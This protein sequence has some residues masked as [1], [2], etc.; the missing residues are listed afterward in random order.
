MNSYPS[1]KEPS[2]L[3]SSSPTKPVREQNVQPTICR[4][5]ILVIRSY[6]WRN[7]NP[8]SPTN[9]PSRSPPPRTINIR[10]GHHSEVA[11]WRPQARTRA[12][13]ASQTLTARHQNLLRDAIFDDEFKSKLR[14]ANRSLDPSIFQTLDR[15]YEW[16]RPQTLLH[17]AKS[18]SNWSTRWNRNFKTGFVIFSRVE[19]ELWFFKVSSFIF[20]SSSLLSAIACGTK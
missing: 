19:I 17:P 11:T 16:P 10:L 8:S 20:F 1:K 12:G 2:P 14:F 6:S 13:R 7:S 4:A 5:S 18:I 15:H 3:T 9:S